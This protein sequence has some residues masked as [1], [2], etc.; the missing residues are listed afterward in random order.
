MCVCVYDKAEIDK[1]CC[2]GTVHERNV[3]GYMF[4]NIS[5]SCRGSERNSH[6]ELRTPIIAVLKRA[7]CPI[8]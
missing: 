8:N 3:N 5:L 6:T 1:Y 4:S 7:S 2:E